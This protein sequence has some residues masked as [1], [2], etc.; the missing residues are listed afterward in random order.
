MVNLVN[1]EH[2]IPTIVK[3]KIKI[4]TNKIIFIIFIICLFLFL[5]YCKYY[6]PIENHF[7]PLLSV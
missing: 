3:P 2:F 6:Q 4:T 7:Y 1:P 5:G